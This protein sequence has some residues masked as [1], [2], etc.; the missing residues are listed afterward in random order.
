MTKR[1]FYYLIPLAFA[2]LL[3]QNVV[4]AQSTS[5]PVGCKSRAAI[6]EYL[7]KVHG[8]TLYGAG[9][10]SR[11]KIVEL[12]VSSKGNWTMVVT[13]PDGMSCPVA[14]GERWRDRNMKLTAADEAA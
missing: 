4:Y 7:K 6:V 13:R 2:P 3:G 14:V 1:L 9:K 5:L 12:F 10:Q 11:T 8:E